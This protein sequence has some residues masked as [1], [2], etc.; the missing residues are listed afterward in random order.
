MVKPLTSDKT[1]WSILGS[2]FFILTIFFV[3]F[4]YLYTIS[5]PFVIGICMLFVTKRLLISYK[6]QK[7]HL[8]PTFH[9]YARITFISLFW[10]IAAAVLYQYTD[11]QI[12][13][14][15]YDYHTPQSTIAQN[16]IHELDTIFEADEHGH[17]YVEH[18][19]HLSEIEHFITELRHI[20]INCFLIIPLLFIYYFYKAKILKQNLFQLVPI[21]YKNP[22]EKAFNHISNDLGAYFMSKLRSSNA[23]FFLS[24]IGFYVIG[25]K[26]AFLLALM[27]GA[28]HTIPHI[29]LPIAA[30]LSLSI[31]G[32]QHP[33]NPEGDILF[34]INIDTSVR[35]TLVAIIMIS[36]IVINNLFL[37]K[38]FVTQRIHVDHLL[39]IVLIL[40]A[41]KFIGV[42][43]MFFVIPIYIVYKTILREFYTALTQ[44]IVN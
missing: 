43:G 25:L 5:I 38:Y 21:Q 33:M 28:L 41:A 29:G 37:K 17:S 24:A 14:I 44:K 3:L 35:M 8:K 19:L 31:A 1:V 13:S 27:V 36:I 26:G 22:I 23:I 18:F 12:Q 30:L 6:L 32:I 42:M 15:V 39:E 9:K 2:I 40:S 7:H 16:I 4:F 34:F 10:V 20:I 11:N